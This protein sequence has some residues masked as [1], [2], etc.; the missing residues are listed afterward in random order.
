MVRMKLANIIFVLLVFFPFYAKGKETAKL[1]K[2]KKTNILFYDLNKNG[3]MDIYENP[4]LDIESRVE[5]ILSQMTLEEKVGQMLTSLGWHMYERVGDD[6]RLT[7]RLTEE[8]DKYHI[9]SL[10]GFM[11]AD[12]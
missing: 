11:R 4:T 1:V 8:L 2:D 12:P 6:V 10:W 9:G 5:D 7:K 3:K